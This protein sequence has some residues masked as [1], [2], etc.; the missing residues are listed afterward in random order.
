[1]ACR[2]RDCPDRDRERDARGSD[3]REQPIIPARALLIHH[4]RIIPYQAGAGHPY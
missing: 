1:M 3:G 2:I 4:L